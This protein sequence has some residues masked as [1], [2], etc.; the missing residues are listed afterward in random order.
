[1]TF[2]FQKQVREGKWALCVLFQ[3]ATSIYLQ[4]Q[5]HVSLRRRLSL[6]FS[7]SCWLGSA[8]CQPAAVLW[9]KPCGTGICVKL[10]RCRQ[11]ALS[12]LLEEDLN[13][14]LFNAFLGRQASPP[15]DDVDG[16]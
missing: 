12:D 2:N 5:Q 14:E 13:S 8:H 16:A 11:G 6:S 3:R 4:S 15:G 9:G 1:M 10:H 7:L